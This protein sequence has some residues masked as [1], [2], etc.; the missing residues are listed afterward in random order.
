M[1]ERAFDIVVN[2]D[3]KKADRQLNSFEKEIK[4]TQ[5]ELQGLGGNTTNINKFGKAANDATKDIRALSD[6]TD[7]L[8]TG[9]GGVGS[10][11]GGIDG[12]V[13]ELS[14]SM[15]DLAQTVAISNT[16]FTNHSKLIAGDKM[17]IAG[18]TSSLKDN[19]SAL[20]ALGE[21]TAENADRFDEL[22]DNVKEDREELVK[23]NA[24][25][26]S[27]TKSLWKTRA[28]I[29]AVSAGAVLMAANMAKMISQMATLSGLDST[30]FQQ[31]SLATAQFGLNADQTANILKDFNDRIGDFIVTG[32]GPLVDVFERLEKQTGLTADKL[33]SMSG[34]DGLIAIKTAMDSANLSAQ[35]QVFILESLGSDLT[36]LLPL[37]KDNGA[38]L[39][40][41][42][43]E[44]DSINAVVSEGT[45][46]SLNSLS[47][48][49]ADT[50]N[51][52]KAAFL[53]LA[54][55]VAPV[56]ELILAGFNKIV[57]SAIQVGRA[58][59]VMTKF[60]AAGLATVFGDTEGAN[61]LFKEMDD[62]IALMKG[63]GTGANDAS[64]DVAA[65]LNLQD[66]RAAKAG[67]LAKTEIANQIDLA[68]A[69]QESVAAYELELFYQD[70]IN[71]SLAKRKELSALGLRPEQIEAI[72]AQYDILELAIKHTNDQL[73]RRQGIESQTTS[74]ENQLELLKARN[75]EER[76]YLEYQQ[77]IAALDLNPDEQANLDSLYMQIQAQEEMN[78][79]LAEQKDAYQELGSAVTQWA[80]GSE[81]AIIGVIAQMIRLIALSQGFDQNPFV[82]GLVGG[83][84]G[85]ADGGN[86]NAGETFMVGER[87]PEI[88]TARGAGT[89]IPNHQ[90]G[91]MGGTNV[92]ISPTLSI[93]GGV[94]GVDD[95]DAMFSEFAVSIA[96]NTQNLLRNQLR[97]GGVLA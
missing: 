41:F 67:A 36:L 94:N 85:Y 34:P 62:V 91:G 95:I 56:F 54:S 1:A 93:N 48:E 46:E 2:V 74:M 57:G 10:A 35:E 22:T 8:K 26:K 17:E 40:A 51:L 15:L 28:A 81:E 47:L 30:Q 84:N 59:N 55:V 37:L 87:G 70:R 89:V 21:R 32:G 61:E 39:K 68:Q 3:T 23:F 60:A 6:S 53:G 75:D 77:S 38:A 45:L 20:S 64:K 65:L 4:S 19:Q 86:F 18:L 16:A 71:K 66:Q 9:L 29:L 82:Q 72:V 76:E 5:K 90:L 25:L 63:I 97:S 83:L 33:V 14:G 96:D 31:F 42:G 7:E 58:L 92:V 49:F 13:N 80:L 88:I 44:F 11:M 73:A 24:G 50:V 69:A 79:V 52:L 78:R 43:S 27:S 12:D